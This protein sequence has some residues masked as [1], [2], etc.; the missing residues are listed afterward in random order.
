[1]ANSTLAQDYRSLAR[2]HLD[3]A[4]SLLRGP[5]DDL[6]FVCLK[7]RQC[8]EALSYGLLVTYRHELTASAMRSW[9]PRKVLDELETADPLANS[10]HEITIGFPEAEGSSRMILSDVDRRFSPRWANKA[11]NKLSSIL[12]VPT[13]KILESRSELSATEIRTQ[14]A[15][16]ATYLE[17]ILASGVW[18][19]VSGRFLE[20]HCDCGFLIKRRAETTEIGADLECSE[21]QRQYRIASIV[22][23]EVEVVPRMATWTCRECATENKFSAHELE[24]NKQYECSRCKTAVV[25]TKTWTFRNL[26]RG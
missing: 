4:Q 1:M 14:C 2:N 16:Y 5:D 21:C 17:E 9:T 3:P 7:L 26:E 13:P 20:F 12:H 24:E 15:E 8:I 6:M 25:F 23:P 22:G 18:H 10:S 11:Y 19:F